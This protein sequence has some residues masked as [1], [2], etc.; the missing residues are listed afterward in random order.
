MQIMRSQ[1]TY[2]YKILQTLK[3]FKDPFT[4]NPSLLSW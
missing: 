3:E 4:L 2:K 1:N